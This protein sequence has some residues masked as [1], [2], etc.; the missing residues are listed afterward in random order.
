MRRSRAVGLP[1]TALFHH[2]RDRKQ[3]VT[4]A[5]WAVSFHAPRSTGSSPPRR[6]AGGDTA[7]LG[8]PA[9]GAAA[10]AAVAQAAQQKN[11]ALDPPATGCREPCC[12]SV[13]GERCRPHWATA[14]RHRPAKR[15]SLSSS[16]T[17][18]PQGQEPGGS[19][20]TSHHE[21]CRFRNDRDAEVAGRHAA[22]PIGDGQDTVEHLESRRIAR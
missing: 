22:I 9:L 8:H 20:K 5:G 4:Q 7:R 6:H 18:A 21:T 3:Q 2:S 11:K 14:V 17:T 13:L 19:G 12:F 16:A 15:S 1:T 10:E